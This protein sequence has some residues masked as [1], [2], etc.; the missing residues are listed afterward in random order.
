MAE[1]G[2]VGGKMKPIRI[3][4]IIVALGLAVL[5]LFPSCFATI[6]AR[7]KWMDANGILQVEY[8][9][10]VLTDLRYGEGEREVYDLYLPED[11]TDPKATH[12]ILFIH[13]GSWQSGS[14]NDGELW[15]RN[16]ASKGYT[17]ATI[18]YTLKTDTTDTNIMLVNSQVRAAVGAIKARCAEADIGINLVDMATHGFSAG[19]CQAMMYGF[20]V[21]DADPALPV[22]FILQQS[23]P[24]TFEPSIWRNGELHKLML[25]STGLN[26]SYKA[27]AAWISQFC[28]EEVTE[29]MVKDGSAEAYWKKVSPYTY[30]TDDSVPI[31]FAYGVL[32]GIVPP[33]SRLVLEQA[34]KEHNVT[35][36]GLVYEKSG[37]MLI[38]DPDKQRL[39]VEYMDKFCAKYFLGEDIEI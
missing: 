15:C 33:A 9:G 37:H 20:D 26:G 18:S 17:A 28:G 12:L 4:G 10:T 2:K 30:I 27:D 5:Q 29:Q 39:F 25:K 1:K 3:K 23:G 21:A 11:T 36:V 6:D 22:K 38:C 19:A 8:N 16:I 13:G 35:N 24:S 31:L 14:K 7:S 34:L 32:D